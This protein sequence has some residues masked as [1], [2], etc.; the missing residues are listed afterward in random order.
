MKK[1]INDADNFDN[2]ACPSCSLFSDCNRGNADRT[3]CARTPSSCV[4]DDK[5][6]CICPQCSVYTDN[7]L[8]GAYFCIVEIKE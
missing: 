2:C 1:P 8:V 5:K 3:F 4:M 7:G 6:H